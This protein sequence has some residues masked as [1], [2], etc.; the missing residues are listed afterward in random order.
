MALTRGMLREMGLEQEQI[1][2]IMNAHGG[3]MAD[4]VTRAEAEELS[5]KNV[6]Q[7]K[8]EWEKANPVRKFSDFEEYKK[9]KN[10]YDS[11]L[12]TE[13]LRGAKVKQKY[14]DIVKGK[15]DFEHFDE[16]I[17]KLKTDFGEFFEEDEAEAKPTQQSEVQK[18]PLPVFG[19]EPKQNPMPSAEDAALAEIKKAF[20]LN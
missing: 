13:Q 7:A 2:R 9:L 20:K 6:E 1:D 11:L 8:T 4:M 3:T 10:D 17:K 12:H 14:F 19:A 5:K 16:S 18:A 15:T